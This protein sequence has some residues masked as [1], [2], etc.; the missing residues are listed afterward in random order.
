[1]RIVIIGAGKLGYSIAE[2]LSNE[3]FDVVLVDRD[4][5]RL[6]AAKNTL[7]VLTVAANGASPITMDDP[8]IRGA[9]VLI[10]VTASDEVN[11]VA[12]ILAK[13]HGI[14]HTAA[15]I[16][17][18]QFLSEGKE[19]LKKNFDIDLMLNPELI[20]AREV[21][22]ILMTPAALDVEDFASGKVRL[23]ETKVT[24]HS[25]LANI[26]LKDL[27][28]PKAILAG[29]IF[30]DHRMII[31]HG[32]DCLLPHDNAYFIGDPEEIEKF[33]ENF[34]HRDAKKL[35]HVM[36]IGAG[37]TGRF[38]AK[39]LDEADVAVKVI[40]LNDERSRLAADC[41][42]NG[43]AICGDGTDID[44]LTEEGVAN[45]DVVVCLTE[46]DKL[47]LMLALLAKHLGAGRTVVRV[48]RNEYVDLMEKVGVDIVLSARLLSAGEVLA[49]ARRGGVVSVSF[50]EGAKAEAVE[51]IVQE[52]APVAGIRLMDARLPRECLVCAYVRDDEAVIPNGASV[53]QPGDRTILFIQMGFAQ[54]VMKYFKGKN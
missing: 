9:D 10:A 49:F 41:L 3:A 16:R 18:M 31:P 44:L 30:R 24:R 33:S 46:D 40:E 27:E 8:D 6:E 38:L 17:D 21:Y 2:L 4:E 29:M 36:I 19:Y 34:V 52:G 13:K 53:L 37:R 54:K 50:L 32:D 5:V 25:P 23:F 47:N 11:M 48:A 39:M 15:R 26:P 43:L 20:T 14:T 51:V 28:M 1:M 7:D 35:E 22:R 12:C 42:D 45:A